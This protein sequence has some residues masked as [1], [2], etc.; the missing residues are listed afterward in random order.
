MLFMGELAAVCKGGE[1]E[2][3]CQGNGGRKGRH[4]SEVTQGIR[5]K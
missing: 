3:L 2:L 4:R 5:V 1:Q